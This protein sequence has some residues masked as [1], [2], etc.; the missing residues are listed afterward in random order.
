M[1]SWIYLTIIQDYLASRAKLV[2]PR[3]ADPKVVHVRLLLTLQL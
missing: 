3:R 1:T 2:D